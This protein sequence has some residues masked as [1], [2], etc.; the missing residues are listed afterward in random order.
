MTAGLDTSHP[1]SRRRDKTQGREGE[2]ER[3]VMEKD[4]E[5][6]RGK[7]RGTVGD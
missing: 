6:E 5:R 3:R 7:E 4:R 2:R 1:L